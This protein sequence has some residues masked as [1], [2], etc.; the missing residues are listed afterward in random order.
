MLMVV[1][2]QS[3]GPL[4]GIPIA[5]KDNFSTKQLRTTAASRMLANYVP[6]YD[7]TVVQK[8]KDAG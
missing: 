6:I 3:R 2:G 8:L 7:A 4:D 1:A 5:V